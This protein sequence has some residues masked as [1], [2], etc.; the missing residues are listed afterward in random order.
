ML[1]D[2]LLGFCFFGPKV[3][4]SKHNTPWPRSQGPG[5]HQWLWKHRFSP[6][7]LSFPLWKCRIFGVF[8]NFKKNCSFFGMGEHGGVESSWLG[9][10][11]RVQQGTALGLSRWQTSSLPCFSSSPCICC[12]F[13]YASFPVLIR[14][15]QTALKI[16]SFRAYFVLVKFLS[17]LKEEDNG[18]KS[19]ADARE[20]ETG[21]SHRLSTHPGR[22]KTPPLA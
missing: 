2:D 18:I 21:K 13:N 5:G 11:G 9:G 19:Y 4:V 12:M 14:D 16:S 7:C 1:R 20:R 8:F 22:A 10:T 17:R 6:P 3:D 15:L